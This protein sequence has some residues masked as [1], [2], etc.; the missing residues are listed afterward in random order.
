MIKTCERTHYLEKALRQ[1]WDHTYFKTFI[2]E[3]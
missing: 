3:N 1:S 2:L